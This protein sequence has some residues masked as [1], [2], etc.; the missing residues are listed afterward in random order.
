MRHAFG[1]ALVLVAAITASAQ[2]NAAKCD[3]ENFRVP[4]PKVYDTAV[5]GINRSQTIVGMYTV[6]KKYHGYWVTMGHGFMLNNGRYY[7]ID[8]PGRAQTQPFA[9]NDRNEVAGFVIVAPE[10][11]DGRHRQAAN[12]GDFAALLN[13]CGFV[14]DDTFVSAVDRLYGWRAGRWSMTGDGLLRVFVCRRPEP[15]G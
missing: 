13:Q 8:V 7:P 5:N 14:V 9:L 11:F 3:F 10:R 1:A 6:L 15:R 4:F 2:N 12:A